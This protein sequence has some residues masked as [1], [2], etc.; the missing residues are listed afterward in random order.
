VWLD[1]D[2]K[3]LHVPAKLARV[4]KVKLHRPLERTPVTAHLVQR[5]DGH[6]YALIVCETAPQ[7]VCGETHPNPTQT[8][9][10][11]PASGLDIGLQVFLA[12]SEGT[13]VANPRFYRRGQRCLANAQHVS[14]QRKKGSQRRRKAKRAVAKH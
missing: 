2:G 13:V 9:C 5:A 6:W 3:H 1:E 14:D 11:H 8:Q 7:D 4:L 12:D 10:E